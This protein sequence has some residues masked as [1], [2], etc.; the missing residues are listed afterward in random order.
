MLEY[1][2]PD[3]VIKDPLLSANVLYDLARSQQKANFDLILNRISDAGGFEAITKSREI[4]KVV[5]SLVL[6]EYY[7]SPLLV[8][9]LERLYNMDHD[10]LL[11]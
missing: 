7:D 2:Q 6:L 8:E 4:V 3:A 10:K 1:M 11:Q 9:L 5:Y